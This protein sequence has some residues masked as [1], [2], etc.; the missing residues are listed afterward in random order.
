MLIK[1]G[2]ALI[3]FV[4]EEDNVRAADQIKDVILKGHPL[5][6]IPYVQGDL[7]KKNV[8]EVEPVIADRPRDEMKV[9]PMPRAS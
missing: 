5:R 6:L 9:A 4:K 7:D 2:Q 3:T 8:M 1:K